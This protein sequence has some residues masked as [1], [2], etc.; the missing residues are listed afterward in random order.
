M[1]DRTEDIPALV[2]HFVERKSGGKNFRVPP[3]VSHGAILRLKKYHWPGN[4][5]ELENVVERASIQYQ[6]QNKRDSL[7]AKDLMLPVPQQEYDTPLLFGHKVDKPLK[8]DEAMS[9]HIQEVLKLTKGKIHGTGG[10]AE[11][12]GINEYT[13]RS[14]MSKLGIHYK[15]QKR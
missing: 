9:V 5:R 7:T 13:L 14:R 12:L 10:A 11:L 1:R 8:L 4:V 6:G 2:H 15:K 3:A